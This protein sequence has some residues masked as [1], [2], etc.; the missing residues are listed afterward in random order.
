MGARVF[1]F[2]AFALEL[3]WFCVASYGLSS[4]QVYDFGLNWITPIWT[5]QKWGVGD[6]K[7]SILQRLRG[8]QADL[9]NIV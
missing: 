6:S 2:Y 4:A 1:P 9:E 8:R 3:K 5:K 7:F